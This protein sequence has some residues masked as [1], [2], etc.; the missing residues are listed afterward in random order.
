MFLIG[1][2]S[3]PVA[4]SA[5]HAWVGESGSKESYEM[6]PTSKRQRCGRWTGQIWHKPY[7]LK[8][9]DQKAGRKWGANVTDRGASTS[10]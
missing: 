5:R 9:A 2:L 8:I 6:R 10:T 4:R 3:H 1:K 7:G